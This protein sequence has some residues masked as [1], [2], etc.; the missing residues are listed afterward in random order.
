M[1]IKKIF[2][3][4]L[5]NILSN[6]YK[7]NEI[8]LENFFNNNKKT[9]FQ[10]LDDRNTQ[11]KISRA[12]NHLQL[13]KKD[14]LL[15]LVY[16][17]LLCEKFPNNGELRL[18]TSK[19]CYQ[20]ALYDMAL[21]HLRFISPE[22]YSKEHY[23]VLANIYLKLEYFH[24]CIEIIKKL[25]LVEYIN[26]TNSLILIYC[27]RR[28][29]KINEAKLEL[30]NL[31]NFHKNDFEFFYNETLLELL[32]NKFSFVL[33][34]L[35]N[36][37]SKYSGKEYRFHEVY[38]LV[39]RKYGKFNESIDQLLL[40]YSLGL[41]DISSYTYSLYLS[42]GDFSNGYLHLDRATNNIVKEKYFISID[43]KKWNFENLD[44]STLFVY[45]GKG[46]ALGDKIY[47]YRYLIDIISRYKGLNVFLCGDNLRDRY[48]FEYQ[49]IN[50]IKFDKINNFINFRHNNFYASLSL[51]VKIY[52]ERLSINYLKHIN[53]LPFHKEKNNFW[54]KEINKIDNKIKIGINWKGDIKYKLDVYRSLELKK[55]KDIFEIN[56][57]TFII[58]NNQIDDE[59]KKFISKYNNIILFDKKK[60]SDENQKT[61]SETIEIMRHL[62]LIISTD[63]ALAHLASSL[64]LKT[65]LMLEYAPFW[66]WGLDEKN[67]LYNNLNL[68]YFKQK[69][70]GNWDIVI[71]NVMNEIKTLS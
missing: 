25:R 21:S 45:A 12:I 1:N 56:N 16:L 35:I 67:N 6:N 40:A 50:Y 53:F 19:T 14:Y 7:F 68:K 8:A 28:L 42:K 52:N 32:E 51:I 24:E 9:I 13:N 62:D 31:K 20:C 70:P 54:E 23:Q 10:I 38:S 33:D 43:I 3:D 22:K 29:R 47:F 55:L 17:K 65:F 4:G 46:I 34:K 5:S 63:T 60:F 58:L 37:E 69:E 2:L 15:S 57:V 26:S 59:E 11:A 61:F 44:H 71:K 66:Y 48:I 27:L 41:N 64:N 30:E 18:I 49:N 36:A 39:Q